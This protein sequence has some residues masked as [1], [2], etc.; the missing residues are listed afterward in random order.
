MKFLTLILL[1]RS[2][3]E[4]GRFHDW[5]YVLRRAVGYFVLA[6][7]LKLAGIGYRDRSERMK[8]VKT[9]AE[10]TMVIETGGKGKANEV[11]VVREEE[12]GV[13]EKGEAS[14]SLQVL[15]FLLH[16]HVSLR[17]TFLAG[18]QGITTTGTIEGVGTGVDPGR[19]LVDALVSDDLDLAPRRGKGQ[20]LA[21]KAHICMTCTL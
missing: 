13:I 11:I 12:I 4:E 1:G 14:S 9:G 5:L 6:L 16:F 18:G 3:V 20:S 19:N 21:Y 10:E 8:E 7:E 17:R 15:M 2:N